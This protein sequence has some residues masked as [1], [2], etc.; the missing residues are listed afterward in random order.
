MSPVYEVQRENGTGPVRVLHRYLLLQC[1]DLPIE[2]DAS[3]QQTV[4]ARRNRNRDPCRTRSTTR[5][6]NRAIDISM[7]DSDS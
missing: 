1:T 7:S 2:A 5:L 6:S 3:Q 4:P